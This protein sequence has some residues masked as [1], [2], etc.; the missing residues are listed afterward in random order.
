MNTT[1]IDDQL[2]EVHACLRSAMNGVLSARMRE[3]GMPYKLVFGVELPRLE[4]IAREFTPDRR[5]AQQLWNENIRESKMLA[6]MLMPPAE[7]LPEMADIWV[8][9]MP[10]AEVAQ[11]CVM[12]LLVQEPWAADVA[13]EWIAGE[14]PM[15]QLCGFLIIARLLARGVQFQERSL[16]EL[17]DQAE[18]LLPQA[19]LPLRKAIHAA[20]SKI[21]G[22][23]L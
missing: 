13:F 2:R 21:E 12:F 3:A 5:L 9:E 11:T 15:R 16:L 14:H 6:S 17:R 10:T 4:S 8:E 7:F 1:P 19:D 18:A 23:N 20:I 22:E